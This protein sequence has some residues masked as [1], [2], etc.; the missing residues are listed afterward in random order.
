[1]RAARP[2]YEAFGWA[3]DL[4]VGDPVEPWTHAV[5]RALEKSGVSSPARILDAGCG[6]GRHAA[7]LADAGHEISLVDSSTALLELAR[8]RLPSAELVQQDLRLL[9]LG[10]R[11]DAITCRGVLNDVLTPGDRQ[12]VLASF[13]RH[14]R[15]RGIVILDVRDLAGTRARYAQERQVNR[16]LKTPR[17]SLRYESRGRMDGNL[18][19]FVERHTL[20]GQ[21]AEHEFTMRP[22]TRDELRFRLTAAGFGEVEIEPGAAGRGADR[23]WCQARLVYSRA[24]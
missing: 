5:E 23:V 13:A 14:L 16:Q 24:T 17:G 8:E 19:R 6:S 3:Y 10:R 12:A 2:F 15:P 11:F 21:A 7:A 4:L 1:L 18:L 22:W 20:D 9:Q